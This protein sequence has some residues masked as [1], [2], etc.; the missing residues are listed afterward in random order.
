MFVEI[1]SATVSA[2]VYVSTLSWAP[3]KNTTSGYPKNEF[4]QDIHR[5]PKYYGLIVPQASH[6][7]FPLC[8]NWGHVPFHSKYRGLNRTHHASSTPSSLGLSPLA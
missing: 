7:A 8:E 6:N 3:E 1:Y 2:K 5:F 4:H